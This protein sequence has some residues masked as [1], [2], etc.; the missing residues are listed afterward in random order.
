MRRVFLLVVVVLLVVAGAPAQARVG[1]PHERPFAAPQLAGD[2]VVSGVADPDGSLRLRATNVT[3]GV[4]GV[5]RDLGP[6]DEGARVAFAADEG[7]LASAARVFQIGTLGGAPR[8]PG[9]PRASFAVTEGRIAT[10]C[11]TG[12]GAITVEDAATGDVVA[13]VKSPDGRP[14]PVQV[15]DVEGTLLAYTFHVNRDVIVVV[16]YVTGRELYRVPGRFGAADLDR[17]GTLV[18]TAK[19][20]SGC[21]SVE[22]FSEADPTAHRLA[23]CGRSE[24]LVIDS[25]RIAATTSIGGV[26]SLVV[27]DL[28]GNVQ[29]ILANVGSADLDGNRLAYRCLDR[30]RAWVESVSESGPNPCTQPPGSCSG[31][32]GPAVYGVPDTCPASIKPDRVRV[33]ANG[34]ASMRVACVRGCAASLVLRTRGAGASAN[35]AFTLARGT[36]TVRVRVSSPRRIPRA[37]KLVRAVVRTRGVEGVGERYEKT[38]RVLPPK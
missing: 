3:T 37:G 29:K 22:W 5:V 11:L 30:D 1:V 27:V 20:M 17:D 36:T 6:R 15:V 24:A 35:R 28:A 9:C 14:E 31:D 4:G 34:A 8:T 13:A 23:L 2:E 19:T 33:S 12:P 10:S 25:G 26:Q 16:D 7:A 32:P 38:I 18:R 21:D